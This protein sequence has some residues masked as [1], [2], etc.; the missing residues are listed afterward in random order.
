VGKCVEVKEMFIGQRLEN[1]GKMLPEYPWIPGCV[2]PTS[3]DQPVCSSPPQNPA[4]AI[5]PQPVV[6]VVKRQTLVGFKYL[7]K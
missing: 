3:K 1:K 7:F 4:G 5:R 6:F 2:T